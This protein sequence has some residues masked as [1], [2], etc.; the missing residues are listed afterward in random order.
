MKIISIK[1][2]PSSRTIKGTDRYVQIFRTNDT[3]TLNIHD[4]EKMLHVPLLPD[5]AVD[6]ANALLREAG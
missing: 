1:N 2:A 4:A 3:V 6:I 5:E